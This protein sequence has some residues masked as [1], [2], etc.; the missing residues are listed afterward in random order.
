MASTLTSTAPAATA[1]DLA[2]LLKARRQDLINRWSVTVTRE[3]T[4]EPISRAELL[5]HIPRFIDELI[6]ALHPEALSLTSLGGNA[7]EHGAQRLNQGLNVA[8]VVREYGTLHRCII[9]I[10]REGIG[11]ISL[12]EQMVIAK[13]LNEGL[14]N[15]VSQYVSDRD[16][17][18][19]LQGPEAEGTGRGRVRF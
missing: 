9:E 10:A 14:A 17:E 13:W 5:D 8:E 15:A 16:M 12:D 2:T 1:S 18:L 3:S 7:V 19:Q 6:G 11:R 4:A